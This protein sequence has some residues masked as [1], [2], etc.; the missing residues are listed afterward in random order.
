MREIRDEI[1][2]KH[3]G[4][5]EKPHEDLANK[6]VSMSA[7]KLLSHLYVS[8]KSNLYS[9]HVTSNNLSELQRN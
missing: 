1:Y 9:F 8:D 5:T 2:H 7:L 4:N 6:Y 3:L